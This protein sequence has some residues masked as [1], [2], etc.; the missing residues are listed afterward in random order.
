[1]AN[2]IYDKARQKFLNGEIS[3]AS[4]TIKVA[5]VNSGYIS[6]Q[7]SHT[8][9]NDIKNSS[10]VSSIIGISN[11]LNGKTSIDGV[12]SANSITL[13]GIESGHSI[14]SLIIFRENQNQTTD[15]I[16][17]I[18]TASGIDGGLMTTGNNITISW[19]SDSNKI[20]KL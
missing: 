17:F 15:L 1:M 9:L 10:G 8:S 12:A 14:K 16:A 13:E 19:S 18:D 6:N 3:W 11:Q 5:L 7:N 2:F 20:F 4:D